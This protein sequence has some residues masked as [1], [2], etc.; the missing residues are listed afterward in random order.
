M[1]ILIIN[2][3]NLNM[4]G[5][6]EPH[7]YGTQ[8]LDDINNELTAKYPN[9][10]FTFFQSNHEGAIVDALQSTVR[11]DFDGVV[12]NGAAFTHYSYA[13]RDAIAI[14]MIPVVE[15]HISNIHLREEFRRHSVTAPV[16]VA[17]LS[18]FGSDGYSLAVNMLL[19]YD[20]KKTV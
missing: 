16:C 6:R 1:N 11:K 15:V 20:K 2:G 12:L 13:I 18:G 5:L 7:I 14:L 9:V 10:N 3:P 8:T 19:S 4:L 17:Q